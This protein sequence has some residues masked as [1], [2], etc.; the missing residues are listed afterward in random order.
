VHGT[1]KRGGHEEA[2]NYPPISRL[3]VA[4]KVFGKLMAGRLQAG[5]SR[6]LRCKQFGLRRG[7]SMSEPFFV[8]RRLIAM[9]R[10]K[11]KRALHL[12][13]L[14]WAKGVRQGGYRLFAVG[15]GS[16]CGAGGGV[17]RAASGSRAQALGRDAHWP[18]SCSPWSSR[19]KCAMW[20][21][22]CAWSTRWPRPRP[23][24]R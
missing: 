9:A 23:C 14:D 17:R 22:Q 11:R 21:A 4:Y 7:H 6:A 12:V 1:F 15:F 18:H 24:P 19:P 13:F 16:F 5:L 8:V 10:S 3:G 20:S 2:S